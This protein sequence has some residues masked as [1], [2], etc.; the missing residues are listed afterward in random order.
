MRFKKHA[1]RLKIAGESRLFLSLMERKLGN[2]VELL[3]P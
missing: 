1:L 2:E 3:H